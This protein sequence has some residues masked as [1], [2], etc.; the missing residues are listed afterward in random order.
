[1][2]LVPADGEP[3]G[4]LTKN[5]RANPAGSAELGRPPKKNGVL[6]VATRLSRANDENQAGLLT[7]FIHRWKESKITSGVKCRG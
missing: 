3:R 4:T 1:M 7:F 6:V 2:R 5:R